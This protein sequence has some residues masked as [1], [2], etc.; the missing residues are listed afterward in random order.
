MSRSGVLSL[1][2]TFS[3]APRETD[4]IPVC[5]AGKRVWLI[6]GRLWSRLLTNRYCRSTLSI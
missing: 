5:Y 2:P 6:C 4:A 1:E 3:T